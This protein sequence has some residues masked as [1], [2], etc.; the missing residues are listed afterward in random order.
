MRPAV[1][2]DRDDTL[3]ANRSLPAS[4][5]ST[6]GDLADPERVELL[7]GAHE[8]CRLLKRSGYVLVIVSNQGIVARGGATLHDV[9]ATNDRLCDLLSEPD[10][11]S[12][13][14]RSLI[15][16]VYFCPF[17][18][19]GSVPEFTR[20]HPWRKPAPGMILAA[21]EHLELDLTR[22]WLI[23]DAPRD[24]QAGVAAGIDAERCLRIGEGFEGVLDAAVRVL[25]HTRPAQVSRARLVAAEEGALRHPRV[26]ATVASS[27]RALAERTGVGLRDVFV[28]EDSIEMEVEGTPLLAIGM[29]AELRRSTDAW[30]LA[31]HGTRLW[32]APGQERAT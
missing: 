27:V 24:V 14:P 32:R 19:E 8:A 7:E 16:A 10:E 9:H 23:G 21:A 31:K 15:D 4:P 22:S 18:P 25:A 6:P 1:F 12:G 13:R 3:I 20:E 28:D 5:G 30:H 2:L 29:A 17:H 11:H 26:R